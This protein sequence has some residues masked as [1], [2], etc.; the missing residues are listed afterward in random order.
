MRAVP[1]L[2]LCALIFVASGF[3]GDPD[4]IDLAQRLAGPAFD[5]PL[6]TDHLGRDVAARLLAGGRDGLAMVL[7]STALALVGGCA[8][9]G[10]MLLAPRFLATNLQALANLALAVPTL[11]AALVLSAAL[12]TQPWVLCFA[13]ALN[14]AAGTAH[15]MRTLVM[16]HW[17][18]PH[19]RAA[20]ALG[21]SD[22]HIL[23]R[24]VWPA[25]A[26]SLVLLQGYHA[27]RILLSWSAL[28]FLGLGGDTSK[29][30]WGG[31]IWEYR[32]SLFEHPALPLLPAGAI[33]LLALALAISADPDPARLSIAKRGSRAQR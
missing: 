19:V 28:T 25:V 7:A 12:G 5:H 10:A 21:G 22:W 14:G 1:L 17:G 4:G 2:S 16:A 30:N 11:V 33:G 8:L 26:P 32:M 6:G 23:R 9:G 31:M 15:V 29:P 18:T 27:G 20:Y 24:H 3:A 13:L